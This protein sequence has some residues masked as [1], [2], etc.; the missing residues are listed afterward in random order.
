MLTHNY[1][2]WDSCGANAI[3]EMSD[4]VPHHSKDIRAACCRQE[5]VRQDAVLWFTPGVAH[6]ALYE[7]QG[8]QRLVVGGQICLHESCNA[9]AT[10]NL[11]DAFACVTQTCDSQLQ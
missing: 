10:R 5:V 7:G 9:P 1:L 11:S 3:S 4:Q 6:K 2:A 8:D